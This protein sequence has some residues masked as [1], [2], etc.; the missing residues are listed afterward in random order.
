MGI[1]PYQGLQT[2]M[3]VCSDHLDLRARQGK[4]ATFLPSCPALAAVAPDRPYEPSSLAANANSRCPLSLSLN[5]SKRFLQA[6]LSDLAYLASPRRTHAAPAFAARSPLPRFA[7]SCVGP[8]SSRSKL[9]VS[10]RGASSAGGSGPRA[11]PGCCPLAWRL[12]DG[13][14][15]L[16]LVA[17]RETS[18]LVSRRMKR[19]ADPCGICRRLGLLVPATRRP[20]LPLPRSARCRGDH[21]QRIGRHRGSTLPFGSSRTSRMPPTLRRSRPSAF[22]QASSPPTFLLLLPSTSLPI[23]QK[24]RRS[25][26]RP[27]STARPCT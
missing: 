9:I 17:C 26:I 14:F 8:C 13:S 18:S 10:L 1:L 4:G 20:L 2:R 5:L 25:L 6:S 15:L 21:S 3:P 22:S 27:R 11:T 16:L 23:Q 24:S 12:R 7:R 19:T